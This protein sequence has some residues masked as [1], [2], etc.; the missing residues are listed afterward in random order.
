[1]C[2]NEESS[3]EKCGFCFVKYADEQPKQLEWLHSVS[4]KGTKSVTRR[5][6][7]APTPVAIRT[8]VYPK[9][10]ALA[11]CS[12]NCKWYS[13]LPLR[14]VELYRYFVSQSSEFCRRKSLCCFSTSVYLYLCKRI[15]RYRLSPEL[16][17]IHS[18]LESHN[19]RYSDIN[20]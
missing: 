2:D 16:L 8:R 12:K 1:M 6:F 14:A 5:L 15:F 3:T 13:S 4:V 17:D 10:S 11:A 7:W 9:F 19:F 18:Y 20:L